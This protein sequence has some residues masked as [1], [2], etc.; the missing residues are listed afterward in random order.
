MDTAGTT[1]ID[2]REFRNALGCFATGI[3]VITALDESRAPVGLTANSF[4]SLSLDPPLVLFCIDRTI[5]SFQAIHANRHFVVNILREDQ[6][7]ISR[8]FAKSGADKWYGVRFQSW[9]TGCPI[10]E[11][12]IANLECDVEQVF[13]GGDHIIVVG[14]VRRMKFDATSDCRPLLYYKGKYGGVRE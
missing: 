6:E 10:L 7:H 1:V 3:T 8:Q 2:T 5:K 9:D 13:E 4:T 12:C 11:G 14:K